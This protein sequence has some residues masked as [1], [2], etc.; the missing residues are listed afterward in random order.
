MKLPEMGHDYEIWC[1]KDEDEVNER[2]KR[3]RIL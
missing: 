2:E 1:K 3:G